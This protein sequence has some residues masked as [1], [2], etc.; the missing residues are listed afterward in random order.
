MGPQKL[1]GV[2]SLGIRA[3]KDLGRVLGMSWGLLGKFF[4]SLGGLLFTLGIA[5]HA[6]DREYGQKQSP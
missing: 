1:E 5:A 2:F 6:K 3:W 4:E